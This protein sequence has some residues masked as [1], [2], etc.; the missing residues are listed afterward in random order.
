MNSFYLTPANV[1]S[2]PTCCLTT[3]VLNGKTV[4]LEVERDLM[5]QVLSIGPNMNNKLISHYLSRAETNGALIIQSI[6]LRSE[7]IFLNIIFKKF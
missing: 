7:G 4:M 2:R 5:P 1:H 6:G 3:F